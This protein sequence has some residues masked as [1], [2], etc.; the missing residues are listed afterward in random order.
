MTPTSTCSPDAR[1]AVDCATVPETAIDWD[2][3]MIDRIIAG[4]DSALACV[5]DQYGALVHG[6]ALRLVGADAAADICQDVFVTLW[7]QP[8]GWDPARGNL[9]VF[10]AVVARRRSIDQLR[11]TGRRTANEQRAQHAAPV[12][13]PNVD[14]AAIALVTGDRVRQALAALPEVQRHSIELAYFEGLT[15]RQVA[16]ATGASEGTA[17]S[18]IRLGLRRLGE[19]L[20]TTLNVASP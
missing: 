1:G 6:I 17:K 13:V 5:Y 2:R 10:L 11:K 15:Y 16:V 18:R 12:V 4:D 20:G 8:D 3:Q 9:R 19:Q 14:E 7:N